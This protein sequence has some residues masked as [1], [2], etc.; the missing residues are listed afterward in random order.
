MYLRRHFTNITDTQQEKDRLQFNV[1]DVGYAMINNILHSADE[2]T[3]LARLTSLQFLQLLVNKF[4]AASE[5]FD[6]G[7]VTLF[8]HIKQLAEAGLTSPDHSKS[9]YTYQ[10]L[11]YFTAAALARCDK[12]DQALISIMIE[13]LKHPVLGKKVALSFRLLLGPSNVLTKE[14]FCLVR[15]LRHGRL[16]THSVDT[17]ISLWRNGDDYNIKTNALIALAGTLEF[18]ESAVYLDHAATILPLLLEGTN[19]QDNDGRDKTKTACIQVL[20]V[21]VDSS[22][23]AVVPHLD[24]IINRMIDRIRNTYFNPSDSKVPTRAA[25]L[26]VLGLLVK[27]IDH[28]DLLKRKARVLSELSNAVD[29]SSNSVRNRAVVCKLEW[30]NL[31]I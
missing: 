20:R 14:N 9:A 28:Q 4:G 23:D 10:T 16:Y 22:P 25:A 7:S 12:S 18:M 30:S 26:D 17:I 13:G 21:F 11:A 1:G 15:P 31:G 24:S 3:L 19:I 6:D 29:D 8:E 27:K 5:I 2:N